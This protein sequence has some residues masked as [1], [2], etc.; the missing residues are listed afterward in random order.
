MA[1]KKRAVSQ[2]DS[3]TKR[4]KFFGGIFERIFGG[5]L[6]KEFFTLGLRGFETNFFKFL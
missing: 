3:A 5:L 6:R 1:P 4:G 2:A